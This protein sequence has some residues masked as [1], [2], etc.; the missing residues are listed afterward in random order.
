VPNTV[1]RFG[2][3]LALA[4][5]LASGGPARPA[6]TEPER[7][8]TAAE[9]ADLRP[10]ELLV[11]FRRPERARLLARRV[12]ATLDA[13]SGARVQRLRVPA[14]EERARAAALRLD[15]DVRAAAP[16]YLRRAQVAPDDSLY[17]GQW[18][19]PKIR[20]PSAWDV[21]AGDESIAIAIL[22][23]GADIDHPDLAPKLLPGTNTLWVA[24]EGGCPPTSDVRD[25]YYLGHGTHVAGIAGAATNNATGVAGV[26][27]RPKLIPVKVLDC[28]GSGND[29]QI[30]AGIDWAV[31]NGA[32]VINLSVGG[33]DQSD[34]LDAAVERA[35]RAGVLVIA[36]SGNVGS[37]VPYYP[38]ASPY[39][40]AVGATD[41]S[42]RLTAFSNFGNHIA[43][44]A[45]GHEILSTFL[46]GAY[47]S[48][49]GTS[50]ASPH[51]AGLAGL[52][53]SL[54]PDWPPDRVGD[55]IRATADK[56]ALCPFGVAACPYDAA[57][58]NKWY[59]F[60]RI[61][62]EA[63]LCLAFASTGP[64]PTPHATAVVGPS[65]HRAFLPV[66]PRGRLCL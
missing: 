8:T 58:H 42:D 32:R 30:I 39:V 1:R 54:H 5:A 24:P 48:K 45:P 40:L 19:L 56:V 3:F 50:M 65:G 25:D 23:S 61:N 20:M 10:G 4:I 43:V 27:W 6:A 35:Y 47:Q 38:A 57:G 22:D 66:A 41:P 9:G 59:G 34:V 18:A 53:L 55:V 11:E 46:G 17:P 26:A 52:I 14:G 15:P 29:A 31:A 12:G 62:A 28:N 60:G 33:T 64:T 2:L 37:E 51:V 44:V 13:P 7:S 21:T 16:N 36:A 63:A 49:S